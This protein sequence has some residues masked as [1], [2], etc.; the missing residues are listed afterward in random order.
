M[1]LIRN[2]AV[3]SALVFGTLT[4]VDSALLLDLISPTLKTHL[5]IERR[6]LDFVVESVG[7]IALIYGLWQFARSRFDTEIKNS[8]IECFKEIGIAKNH[9]SETI[10]NG[11]TLDMFDAVRSR[12]DT[13]IKNSAIECFKEIGIAKNHISET[14]INGKTLD[15]FDS[16]RRTSSMLPVEKAIAFIWRR[17]D[18]GRIPLLN[19]LHYH[20]R[21]GDYNMISNYGFNVASWNWLR[22]DYICHHGFNLTVDKSHST[23]DQRT[24]L[25]IIGDEFFSCTM[26]KPKDVLLRL[27]RPIVVLPY[28]DYVKLSDF[29]DRN[30]FVAIYPITKQITEH[31]EGKLNPAEGEESVSQT[32]KKVIRSFDWIMPLSDEMT[33]EAKNSN[34]PWIQAIESAM[35]ED[36]GKMFY[37]FI[38]TG[39]ENYDK[40]VL[41]KFAPVYKHGEFDTDRNLDNYIDV[42]KRSS[43]LYHS[44][45]TESD[46]VEKI[47]DFIK[48]KAKRECFVAGMYIP[49]ID[50]VSYEDT[51][52]SY[53][54]E[55]MAKD[56]G[57]T[58]YG[59]IL[60]VWKGSEVKMTQGKD[61]DIHNQDFFNFPIDYCAYFDKAAII[62]FTGDKDGFR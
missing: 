14:I 36:E 29:W 51:L 23:M 40:D 17:H 54:A 1:N 6:S 30:R 4:I 18:Q 39:G 42:L 38:S 59:P 48:D 55:D 50:N 41:V 37:M 44:D 57:Y 31:V 12:F 8:A 15:M 43:D 60:N 21:I 19:D 32:W 45:N 24:R 47:K 46:D 33:K 28:R 26:Q 58:V 2:F 27:I 61:R 62:N 16:V 10:I 22:V 11:K 5:G 49:I 34:E 35:K 13:E 25:G 52:E 9:I 56:Q 20:I 7:L 53:T 3:G